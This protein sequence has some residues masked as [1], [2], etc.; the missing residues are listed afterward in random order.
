MSQLRFLSQRLEAA[1]GVAVWLLLG[2]STP[3]EASTAAAPVPL[4]SEAGPNEG[5]TDPSVNVQAL[6]ELSAG[7]VEISRRCER[8][9]VQIRGHGYTQAGTEANG[10]LLTAQNTSGSG[11]IMSPDGYILTNAHVVKSSYSLRVHLIS[12]AASDVAAQV[13]DKRVDRSLT[14]TVVGIDSETDLA[15][16]KV[17]GSNLPYLPFADSDELK[18]GQVVL[19]L[20]NPLGLDNSVS[21][22]V[23]SAV[24]RQLKADDPLVYIQTDAPINPGNSGGPLVDIEGRVVGINTFIMTHSGGNE[25]VGFAVPSNTARLVYRQLKSQGRVHRSQLGIVAQTINSIIADGLD[26]EVDRGVIVSD[27]EPNGPAASAGIK[28]EDVIIALNGKRIVNT[29]QLEACIFR[30]LP[31][32]RVILRVRRGA[33]QM[34]VPVVTEEE[35]EGL[36]DL[37]I[38]L[39]P[40]KNTVP[41]LGIAA[42]DL[43]TEVL[44]LMP[45]LRRPAGVV[46]AA[47]TADMPYSGPLLETGDVIY[48][49]NR[50][51]V[52][53]LAELHSTL[54][55]FRSGDAVVLLIER[56]GQLMF[57]PLELN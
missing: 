46:V 2:I 29:G 55:S 9:V 45:D 47:R 4:Q 26:L 16:I 10:V 5:P 3:G 22:G 18:Q 44:Q 17:N 41:E 28:P 1:V 21:L 38:S 49:V 6:R 8:A 24:A 23:V 11:I 52:S 13:D 14:A 56:D 7:F 27:T 25:G 15:V 32:E 42:V 43:T 35:S 50:H 36:Q 53:T 48:E 57:V 33:E 34:D 19:A 37:A 39:D 12:G 51:V 31:G 40:M 30:Q 54:K 20:G